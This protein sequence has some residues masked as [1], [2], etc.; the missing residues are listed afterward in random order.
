MTLPSSRFLVIF[1][2]MKSIINLTKL[3]YTIGEVSTLFDESPSLIRHWDNYFGPLHS[4]RNKK[5]NRLYTPDDIKAI[6]NI[7]NL[8][9]QQG[10]TLEG[11]KSQLNKKTSQ[12]EKV[13]N[14][15][16]NI[17]SELLSLKDAL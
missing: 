8:V 2:T 4:R 14:K 16:L 5:G 12:K 11:A 13:I 17:R 7:Y 1:H 3:Y 10:F 15:L 6:K 9:K